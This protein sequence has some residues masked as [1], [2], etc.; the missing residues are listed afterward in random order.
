MK[1][2]PGVNAAARIAAGDDRT[3]HDGFARAL[4]WLTAVLVLTQFGLAEFWGFS[5]KPT[6]E[7]MIE[8][9]MS[10]GILLTAVLIVRIWWRLM[11]GHQVRPADSGWVELASKAAHYALYGLLVLEAVLGYLLRWSGGEA[12]SFFGLPIPPPF[13]RFSKPAHQLIANAHNWIAWI[14]IILAAGH[15]AA[16]LF[17]HFVLRDDVLWRML[18]GRDARFR[19]VRAASPS[20]ASSPDRFPGKQQV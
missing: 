6:R 10:F 1:T 20:K 8:M 13:A 14:I 4:H 19:E 7:V 18:P 5:A 12:M 9:H 15:A 11:P 2:P 16:A 17:H 3:H